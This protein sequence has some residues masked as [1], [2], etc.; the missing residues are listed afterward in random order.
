MSET[1]TI[2]YFSHDDENVFWKEFQKLKDPKY[3]TSDNK[4]KTITHVK[5]HKFDKS[6]L[7][8]HF[9]HDNRH[10][11][12]KKLLF[13]NCI[14]DDDTYFTE[15]NFIESI[16]F[17][18]C[19]FNKTVYF[20]LPKITNTYDI[21][22]STFN[23]NVFFNQITQEQSLNIE[24][25]IF[26]SNVTIQRSKLNNC[27]FFDIDFKKSK[28]IITKTNLT[29][30]R[31][32]EIKWGSDYKITRDTFRQLKEVM[33]LQKNFI[34]SN[35]FHSLELNEYKKQVSFFSSE[36]DKK[37]ILVINWIVSDFSRS[38][39]RP[40]L[41]LLLG[42]IFLYMYLNYLGCIKNYSFNNFV[43]FFNPLSKSTSEEFSH[44]YGIWFLHKIVSGFFVYHLIVSLKRYF[45]H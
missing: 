36:W 26:N 45:K 41:F 33:E 5:F 39:I 15:Y 3:I 30:V 1:K 12:D 9:F 21:R 22:N 34:D 42:S 27:D 43:L 24:H 2:E 16:T 38:W 37:L 28:L 18:N 31:F 32:N 14:F 11:Y 20:E 17:F 29:G 44:I 13:I 40:L 19:T 23:G 10:S 6:T 25:T 7:K 35:Y 4:S 8:T